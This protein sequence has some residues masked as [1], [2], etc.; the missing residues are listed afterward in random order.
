MYKGPRSIFEMNP[1][2]TRPS[3][4]GRYALGG[5]QRCTSLWRRRPEHVRKPFFV[6]KFLLRSSEARSDDEVVYGV[7]AEEERRSRSRTK[8]IAAEKGGSGH[9]LRLPGCNG[10]NLA[11]TSP[12]LYC[13]SRNFLLV[14]SRAFS[15]PAFSSKRT[16]CGSLSSS[17]F[18]RRTDSKNARN[19]SANFS[20][21]AA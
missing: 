15:A 10:V 6:A 17:A 16:W 5:V 4:G 20:L 19:A 18:F 2:T 13:A 9:A 11:Y 1:G 12:I 21:N 3:A 8:E 14:I 7:Y